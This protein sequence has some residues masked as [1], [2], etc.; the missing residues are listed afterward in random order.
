[1]TSHWHVLYSTQKVM[2]SSQ[3]R[4]GTGRGG[5]AE[6]ERVCLVGWGRCADATRQRKT[7]LFCCKRK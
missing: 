5:Y 2:G 1:M 3:S 4:V 6:E 7:L